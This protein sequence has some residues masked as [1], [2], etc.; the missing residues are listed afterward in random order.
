MIIDYV[1]LGSDRFESAV[2]VFIANDDIFPYLVASENAAHSE[3]NENSWRLKNVYP[4]YGQQIVSHLN[5]VLSSHFQDF[6][7]GLQPDVSQTRSESGL[8]AKLLAKALTGN[9]GDTAVP[10]GQ[11]NPIAISLQQKKRE[12]TLSVWRLQVHSNDHTPDNPFE[13]RIFPSISIAGDRKMV[14]VKHMEFKVKNSQ[15]QVIEQGDKPELLFQYARGDVIDLGVEFENPG[16]KNY[17]VQ[18]KFEAILESVD[19]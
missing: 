4:E 8:L 6:Q 3:W 10:G 9:V 14:P 7:K 17:I 1:K 19:V 12:E 16:R 11:S 18:C 15:G 2:G 13:L 5:S